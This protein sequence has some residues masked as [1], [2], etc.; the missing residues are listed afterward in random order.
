MTAER[1]FAFISCSRKDMRVARFVHRKL[2]SFRYPAGI[3]HERRP[4]NRK[5]VR[6]V[7]IDLKCLA[8]T[9]ENFRVG[10][11]EAVRTSRYLIVICSR[12]SSTPM[13]LAPSESFVSISAAIMRRFP[14]RCLAS[15]LPTGRWA[16][17][18]NRW[19]T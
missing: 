4:Q 7:F 3:D 6:D 13:P 17:I 10:I 14:S 16:T 11:R 19:K 12:H 8:S 18:P 15:A 1:Y 2:E 5:F 9:Q